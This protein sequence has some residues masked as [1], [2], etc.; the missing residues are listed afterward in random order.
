MKEQILSEN[1]ELLRHRQKLTEQ[2]L[3]NDLKISRG[4]YCKRKKEPTSWTFGELL[5]IS[6]Y[7]SKSVEELL[8]NG[9]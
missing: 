9:I 4:T 5:R 2:E 8:N 6:R 1:I 3:C 7:F